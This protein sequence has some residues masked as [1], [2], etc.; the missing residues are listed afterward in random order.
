MPPPPPEEDVVQVPAIQFWPVLQIFPHLPQLSV[1]D[2]MFTQAL[3]HTTSEALKQDVI[4]HPPFV[5]SPGLPPTVQEVPS[6]AL[7]VPT[8]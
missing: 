1:S 8:H 3:V 5:H 4:R 6:A 2:C 7:V